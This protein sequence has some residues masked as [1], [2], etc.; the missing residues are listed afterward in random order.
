MAAA[1][2]TLLDPFGQYVAKNNRMR[3]THDGKEW[4]KLEN[5]DFPRWL[6]LSKGQILT[7]LPGV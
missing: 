5:F 4:E 6:Q 3:R 2:M 1:S 7:F